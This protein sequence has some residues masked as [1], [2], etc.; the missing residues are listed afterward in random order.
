MHRLVFTRQLLRTSWLQGMVT[1]SPAL[2]E[3]GKGFSYSIIIYTAGMELY[4]VSI[5]TTI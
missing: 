2:S 4:K 3:H 1:G 5:V